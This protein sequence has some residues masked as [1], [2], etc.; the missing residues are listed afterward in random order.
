MKVVYAS[1]NGHVAAVINTLGIQDALKI[2]T[3]NETISGDYVIFTYTDGNGILPPNVKTFL[4]NNPGV[5]A[6]VS[7]GSSERHPDTYNFAADIIAKEYG[8]KIIAKIDGFGTD[9]DMEVI[10][11]ALNL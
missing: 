3:G 7:S 2:E 1:R 8:A 9:Q 11:T 10:K 6:V 5:K 4:D